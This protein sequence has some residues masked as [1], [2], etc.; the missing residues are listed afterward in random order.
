MTRFASGSQAEQSFASW[1]RERKTHRYKYWQALKTLR[2]EYYSDVGDNAGMTRPSMHYWVEERY[3][4]RMGL[5]GQGNYT[6]SYDVID[7]K[8]YL[9][10]QIKYGI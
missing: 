6:D 4:F 5:D 10:F 9:L 3:G 8:K 2:Q 1:E 7:P